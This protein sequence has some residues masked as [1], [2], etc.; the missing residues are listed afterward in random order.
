MS[1]Q[2]LNERKFIYAKK[3]RNNKKT[4]P[5]DQPSKGEECSLADFYGDASN[6][7]IKISRMNYRIPAN[8]EICLLY[9]FDDYEPL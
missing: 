7:S 1:C 4:S 2:L 9:L 3:I 8:S 6:N 5:I